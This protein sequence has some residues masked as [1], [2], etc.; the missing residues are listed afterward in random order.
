M[1]DEPDTT[2]R[3][4]PVALVASA[5]LRDPAVR[6]AFAAKM[7]DAVVDAVNH[8]RVTAGLPPLQED[9]DADGAAEH[10]QALPPN[11]K[12]SPSP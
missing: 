7:A 8:R 3:R 11:E 10:A 1:P 4:E 5:D 6:A 9:D 12:K 2:T